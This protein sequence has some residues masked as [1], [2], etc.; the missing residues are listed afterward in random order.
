M[1][2]ALVMS[3]AGLD[4]ALKQSI[5]DCLEQ[6]LE[7]NKQVRED[8]EKFIKKRISGEGDVLELAG[9]AKFLALVL[10]E[11]EPRKRLIEEYIKELTGESLQSTEEIMRTTATLGLDDLSKPDELKRPGGALPFVQIRSLVRPAHATV[12]LSPRNS[13]HHASPALKSSA[14]P[15]ASQMKT[16]TLI[17]MPAIESATTGSPAVPGG[18]T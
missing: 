7:K 8:F 10:A 3:C 13:A 1:R 17:G 15:Q 6:L 16:S 9:G 12:G 11:R 18:N 2:A 14:W 4:A 5:R